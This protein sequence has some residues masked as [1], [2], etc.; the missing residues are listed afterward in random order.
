[1]RNG[2]FLGAGFMRRHGFIA[3]GMLLLWAWVPSASA[4]DTVSVMDQA[5][6]WRLAAQEQT[7]LE[8]RGIVM[9]DDSL[10][11]YLQTVAARLWQQVHT[12]LKP[13]AI[14]VIMDTR[15]EAYAY[16]N[17]HCYL[18]TGILEQIETED[19]LAM[20][21]AHEL[22][23]YVRQHT[24]ELYGHLQLPS[25]ETGL[26][27]ADRPRMAN[28]YAMAK[29]IDAA[30]SQADKEGLSILMGAGYC[31][32]DVLSLMSNL[33]KS[34]QNQGTAEAVKRLQERALFVNSL[35]V[36]AHGR[37]SCPSATG[38]KQE[39]YLGRIAPALI[40]NAQAALQHGDWNRA[41]RSI[42]K[43]MLLKPDDA[44][45]YYL[46]GEILRGRND[47]DAQNLSAGYYETA[48]KIDPQ[49]ALAHRALGEL[50][51]KAGRY[52]KA[53]PYFVTF[54][55]LAPRDEASDYIKGY[56]RQCQDLSITNP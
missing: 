6:L 8:Q 46:K 23:H 15:M 4:I 51:F 40:A 31:E 16:P 27:Y 5:R 22:V 54:L 52:G 17:G 34:V 41:D 29:K 47:G 10:T 39:F 45:A 50:H 42:T 25:P 36:Q 32:A 20:I 21:I 24:A 13:P 35:L 3:A 1:M 14:G 18:T 48:L 12:D 37:S 56:L 28:G 38:A 19:Q 33:T 43:F 49:F 26:Q 9:H 2:Q 30:E 53:K 55:S 44:L 7:T 11:S